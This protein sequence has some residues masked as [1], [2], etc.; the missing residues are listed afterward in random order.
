[1]VKHDRTDSAQLD[2]KVAIDI[3]GIVQLGLDE[4]EITSAS[5]PADVT[6]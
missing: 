5:M 3:I 1:M 2:I 4:V 6:C